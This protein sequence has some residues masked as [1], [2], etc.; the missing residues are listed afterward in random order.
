MNLNFCN[1][2]LRIIFPHLLVMPKKWLIFI[3]NLY[4]I[5]KN[6]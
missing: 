5:K 2:A 1:I 3:F 6:K 4:L